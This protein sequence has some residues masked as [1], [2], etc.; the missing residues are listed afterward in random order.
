MNVTIIY[1]TFAFTADAIFTY[2]IYL[3]ECGKNVSIYNNI[4]CVILILLL[5]RL[6]AHTS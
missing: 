5:D 6:T 4:L 2:I 1:M 3:T